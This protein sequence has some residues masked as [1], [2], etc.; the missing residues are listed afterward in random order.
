MTDD[1]Q[2]EYNGWTNWHTWNTNLWLTNEEATYRAAKAAAETHDVPALRYIVLHYTRAVT[3]DCV[4][5]E[6]V[7]WTEVIES[8]TEE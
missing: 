4:N 5:L 1:G 6:D 2:R 3:G 8:L 7:N